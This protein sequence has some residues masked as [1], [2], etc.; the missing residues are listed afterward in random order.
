MNLINFLIFPGLVF[1]AFCGMLASFIDRKVTARIQWRQGPPLLQPAYDF[2]KLLGK[3]TLVPAGASR[4]TFLAAPLFGFS[5]IIL[6]SVIIWNALRFYSYGFSG[7][8]IVVIYLL[9]IPSISFIMGGF[10]S[11]NP[12]AS[13]GAS[14]EM[15]L[16]LFYE[17]PFV[18]AMI[19]PIIKTG[20]IK[21]TEIVNYQTGTGAVAGSVSGMIALITAIFCIQAKLCLVPFDTP[22]AEQEIIAGPFIE[23][24]GPVLGILKLTHWMMLFVLPSFLVA[25]FFPSATFIG[26]ILRYLIL[27]VVVILLRNTNPRVRIDQ[28]VKFFWSYLNIFVII[29]VIL[30]SV[31]M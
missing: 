3:E 19:I 21:M 24:S 28:A 7:D 17:L 14:R 9:T 18:L 5:A 15:K 13:I 1:T 22:E 10:A 29:G 20:S 25:V 23:Y 16:I 6:V 11:K 8:L 26:N 2:V 4:F 30:A 31:G 12:F 27:L